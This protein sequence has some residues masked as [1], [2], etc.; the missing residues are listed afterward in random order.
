MN[1]NDKKRA[2]FLAFVLIV[3]VFAIYMAVV[4]SHKEKAADYDIKLDAALRMRR[5][6]EKVKEYKAEAGLEI[7][8]L[9]L[10][11]T[12]IIG[13]K[14]TPEFTTSIGAIEA[15]RTSAIPDMA[16]LA[17]ELFRK[18]GLKA[19]DTV[20]AGFSGSFPGLNL[21]VLCAC[22]AMNLNIVYISSAGA[23]TYGANQPELTFPDM[24]YRLVNDGLLSIGSAVITLG[25]E[26]DSGLGMDETIKAEILAR[27]DSYGIPVW[28]IDD[29]DRNIQARMNL[30]ERLGPI[31]CFVGVGG[32]WTTVGRDYLD[33]G[34]GLIRSVPVRF[35]DESSGL[36]ER[37]C[38]LGIPVINLLNVK[39]LAAEYGI[40]YDPIPPPEPGTGQIYHNM[41][42]PRLPI[43]ITL[44]LDIVLLICFVRPT[45]GQGIKRIS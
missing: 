4:F 31:D 37:Y 14:F 28:I 29:Y 26:K 6:L 27:Y 24:A 40:P 43:V 20:G 34:Q 19:G 11:R 7:S 35:V 8:G 22:D 1:E 21:A 30:Y 3:S 9:D 25:G 15:K 5:C 44:I 33:I 41:G 39:K 23:S 13:I 38:A 10:N 2:F 42:Y 16:A 45:R 18:A 36:V 17:A 12:G 32:N